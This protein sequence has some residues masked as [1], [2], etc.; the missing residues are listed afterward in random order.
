MTLNRV[1]KAS[2]KKKCSHCRRMFLPHPK[3]GDRQKTCSEDECQQKRK[4]QNIHKWRRKNPEYFY[5]RYPNTRDWRKNN[6]NYQK[7]WRAKNK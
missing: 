4:K 3:V 1:M 6:P 2:N 7:E 5:C